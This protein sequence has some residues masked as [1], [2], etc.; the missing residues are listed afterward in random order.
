MDNF[1]DFVKSLEIETTIVE[2][3]TANISRLAQLT[4]KTNQFNFNK[5]PLTENELL[6]FMQSGNLVLSASV[7]DKFGDYGII[8]L[9]LVER[10]NHDAVLRNFLMSCRA[11]GRGVETRIVEKLQDW[12]QTNNVKLIRIEF[13]KT[14]KNTPA[15]LFLPAIQEKFGIN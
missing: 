13:N 7:I 10:I 11:L 5:E 1:S 8:G 15:A 6:A 9:M 3:D 2:N 12:L 14:E 4:E